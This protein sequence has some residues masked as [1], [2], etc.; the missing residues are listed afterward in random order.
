LEEAGAGGVC[1]VVC[2]PLFSVVEGVGFRRF[3]YG[4]EGWVGL[5]LGLVWRWSGFVVCSH[6]RCERDTVCRC[7]VCLFGF[8]ARE[9]G[10]GGGFG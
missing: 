10:D 7:S 2:S 5:T 1:V 8:V 4:A 6:I 3:G 9:G